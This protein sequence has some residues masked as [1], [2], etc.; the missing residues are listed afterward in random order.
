MLKNIYP[1]LCS[2]FLKVILDFNPKTSKKC[3]I[4]A[5]DF[6]LFSFEKIFSDSK[7]KSV[8]NIVSLDKKVHDLTLSLFKGPAQ[9]NKNGPSQLSERDE[10]LV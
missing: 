2:S 4:H 10:D 5:V 6:L 3:L 8:K 1:S 9:D 7:Y